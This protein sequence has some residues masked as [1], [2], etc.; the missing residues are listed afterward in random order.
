MSTEVWRVGCS[1]CNYS[2]T[3]SSEA[4]AEL[5]KCVHEQRP[6]GK[7]FSILHRCG[8]GHKPHWGRRGDECPECE[9]NK[10]K[11]KAEKLLPY[12]ESQA[13]LTTSKD[14]ISSPFETYQRA[15]KNQRDERKKE[16]EE[17]AEMIAE[18]IAKKINVKLEPEIIANELGE[19]K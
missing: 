18:N 10:I 13:K 9:L 12:L 4:E 7:L 3:V 1:R 5:W 16:Q 8:N 14:H 17:L 11:R 2:E 6:K 19:D 15:T